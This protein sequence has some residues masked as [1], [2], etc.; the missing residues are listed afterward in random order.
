MSFSIIVC[1]IGR[2]AELRAFLEALA[3]Q[4]HCDFETIVVD[5]SGDPAI[6]RLCAEFQDRMPIR[7]LPMSV[8]GASRAR[9]HGFRHSRGDVVTFADDDCV[10]PPG[11]L[12]E[13]RSH[14]ACAPNVHGLSV[15]S[16]DAEGRASV[17]RFDR[18]PGRVTRAGMF[19]Q[20]VEFGL[21]LR[22]DVLENVPFDED[23]GVGAGTPWGSDEGLDLIVRLL[24][25][26]V[27]IDYRPDLVI[28]HPAPHLEVNEAVIR[29][30]Y[31]YGCGRGRLF[32]KHQFP[33]HVVLIS[34]TR[35][36][37]GAFLMLASLRVNRAR[38]YAASFRGKMRGLI[39]PGP[40]PDRS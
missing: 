38:A 31:S 14:L 13:V 15:R 19:G 28:V 3:E 17:T 25:N 10:Y 5:Q 16:E 32:R 24:A 27:R 30:Q 2:V 22:R 21:F 4:S 18:E 39:A 8:R 35:S 11:L 26:G 1:T 23:M 20:F 12:Q 6:H 7:H 37:V 36:L 40:I 9:N 29:R 34:V 33:P